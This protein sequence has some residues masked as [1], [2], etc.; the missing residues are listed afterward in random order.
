M[1][2]RERSSLCATRFTVS[3]RVMFA[4]PIRGSLHTVLHTVL[5]GR[6]A[7]RRPGRAEGCYLG[8]LGWGY[9]EREKDQ[10]GPSVLALT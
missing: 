1:A 4:L 6:S 8:V 9:R 2:S 10:E 3:P 7:Q 5:R